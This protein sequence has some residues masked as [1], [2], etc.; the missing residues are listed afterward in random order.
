MVKAESVVGL[1]K[2]MK[3]AGVDLVLVNYPGATHGFTNPEATE[4][5]KKF[6]LPLA[7]DRKADQD[8]W[9]Q[10]SALLNKGFL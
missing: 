10:L 9:H 3:A 6:T 5:G 2:E 8:S 4:K 1:E 7:Y